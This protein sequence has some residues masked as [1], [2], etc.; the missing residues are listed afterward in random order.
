[1]SLESLTGGLLH[2]LHGTAGWP[3]YSAVVANGALKFLLTWK[4]VANTG[5]KVGLRA[6]TKT[7]RGCTVY[8]YTH[9]WSMHGNILPRFFHPRS[10]LMPNGCFVRRSCLSP[11][12]QN[13]CS[14]IQHSS[15]EIDKG[16]G[17]VEVYSSQSSCILP[18]TQHEQTVCLLAGVR[19][20]WNIHG[21]LRIN[22][23]AVYNFSRTLLSQ[24]IGVASFRRVWCSSLTYRNMW[25]A[26][27]LCN[28]RTVTQVFSPLTLALQ[29]HERC[30]LGWERVHLRQAR[31]LFS[32]V[33]LAAHKLFRDGCWGAF[34]ASCHGE[35][36]T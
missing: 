8:K 33:R 3:E 20:S 27:L 34:S 22:A 28:P 30:G 19:G 18:F 7:L 12:L 5:Y 31:R 24:P 32:L 16:N 26:D 9:T 17:W 14:W 6:N 13:K 1:M 4:S 21:R 11:G 2:G 36:K 15:M 29:R 10:V 25:G 23:Y 35:F